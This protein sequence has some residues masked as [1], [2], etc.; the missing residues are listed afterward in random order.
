MN[1]NCVYYGGHSTF[2]KYKCIRCLHDDRV[3]DGELVTIDQCLNCTRFEPILGQVYNILDDSGLNGSIILDDMQMSYTDLEGFRNLND[4]THRSSKYFNALATE[5]ANCKKP[6][7]NLSDMWKEADREQA[8]AQIKSEVSDATE[9]QTKIDALKEE[10]YIFKMDWAETFFNAQEPDTKP[11]PNEGIVARQKAKDLEGDG[12]DTLEDMIA[13]LDPKRD[14]AAIEE[15]Q[16]R[17]KIRDGIWVDTREKA[18]AIQVNKYT[19]ENFFFEDFNKVRIGKY[20]IRFSSLYGYN[21]EDYNSVY[22]GPS[23]SPGTPGIQPTNTQNTNSIFAS[24]ARDKIVE[25]AR[26]ILKDGQ[27]GKAW[28][29]QEYRTTEYDK[30]VTIKAGNGTGKIGYDCTSFVSC[31]YMNAG[32]KSM[33]S[34]TC[35]GGTLI[36]EIQKGGKMIPCNKDNMK[37]ILPG[38]ILITAGGTVTQNDC[39]QLKFFTSSHAAIYVGN[40]QIIHARGRNYGIQASSI[41]NYLT[42]GNYVFVRPAD[43]LAADLTASQQQQSTG[44]SGGVDETPG[45]INGKSY[46]AKI[47]QAVCTAYTG[48]GSGASGMG[49]TYNA[50]C[51]SHNLPYGTKIYIPGL[52]GKAGNGIFTVTDTGGCFFDFDIFT[53]TWSGKSNMDAYVLSWGSGKTAASYTWAIN[54]YLSNG[55]W[56]GL[57][58]AWN[59]Y[60]NMNGKL[61]KFTKYN[62][63]DATITSHPNYND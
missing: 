3:H 11:Y 5:E 34:K 38:D 19:S 58:A 50:T 43:L 45:T 55:R 12:P 18:D 44:G 4:I 17:I 26:Q 48:S 63:D 13:E 21:G 39:N 8:I 36:K 20:G 33:Y 41:D 52:V 7:K 22:S 42:K 27:D 40:N 47:P 10:D 37:Y 24:Q 25:M 30:P 46:V 6:E 60:K 57:V 23:P 28:Y 49:C 56:S 29:S 59:T 35:S 62:Q 14:A 16:E 2:N 15:L 54:Y 32:L 31:C 61:M 53:N 9:A 51:A 1:I